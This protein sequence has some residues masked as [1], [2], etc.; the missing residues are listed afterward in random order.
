LLGRVLSWNFENVRTGRWNR[1]FSRISVR[2]QTT[3]RFAKVAMLPRPNRRWSA[4]TRVR[5]STAAV[6]AKKRSAGSWCES[7]SS[8]AAATISCVNGASRMNADALATHPRAF[9]TGSTKQYRPRVRYSESSSTFEDY[10]T[11]VTQPVH[12]RGP[13]IKILVASQRIEFLE[14]IFASNHGVLVRI[15]PRRLL[16]SFCGAYLYA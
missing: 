7:G 1:T 13:G 8:C 6:A 5:P 2:I 15:I 9:L 4:V 16:P 12:L 14:H 11:L 10:P 3:Q